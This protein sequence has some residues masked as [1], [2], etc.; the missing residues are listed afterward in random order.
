MMLFHLSLDETINSMFLVNFSV[1]KIN[2]CR[3]FRTL[4]RLNQIHLNLHDVRS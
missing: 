4:A 3:D 1:N 2:E